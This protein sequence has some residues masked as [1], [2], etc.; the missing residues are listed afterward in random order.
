MNVT[1]NE[2]ELELTGVYMFKNILN[3][4]VYI[5]STTMTFKRRMEHHVW[6]LRSGIHKNSHFQNAWNK[7]G[8]DLFE[9]SIIEIC[10]KD[11]C[12]EREQYYLDT[13]LF[14]NDFI[15]GDKT[16]FLTLSYNINPLASG[17]P[18][19]SP[20]TIEKRT[21][22]IIGFYEECVPY[23]LKFKKNEISYDDIPEKF[24]KSIDS[25]I[26]N[27]VNEGQF[28]LGSEPWNKG[29][30]YISTDH[31]KVPKT[32]TDKVIKARKT[33][34]ENFRN[35][36]PN[37]LVYDSQMNFLGEWRS[38]KDL[39]EWS[40]TLENNLPVKSRFKESKKPG[41]PV[42]YLQTVNIN[43]SC[44]NGKT[45]KGLYFKHKSPDQE[46]ISDSEQTNIGEL[47]DGNTEI[48]D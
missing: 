22:S 41:M 37:I 28:K 43:K 26:E 38:A 46:G 12:L 20:E 39:E 23:F 6:S 36:C 45:Y 21:K 17:T 31:L 32:I 24:K 9:F 4:K 18:N 29:K 2:N 15:S 19:M 8:E 47:C 34:S 3:D 25:W 40:L 10:E 7:Y 33:I 44:K 5:G 1:C 27:K 48:N 35:N 11:K 42:N 13:L 16:K 14:A 30:K